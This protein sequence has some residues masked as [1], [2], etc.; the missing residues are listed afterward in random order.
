MPFDGANFETSSPVTQMLSDGRERVQLGWCQRSMR[1]PGSVCMIGSLTV[2]DFH[3]FTQ[4]EGLVLE[5]IDFLGYP[6]RS[7]P[8]FND[9]AGRTRDQVLEVFDKAIELSKIVR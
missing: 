2:S 7:V 6:H 8:G 4:A 9:A 5:A 3:T 1:Q